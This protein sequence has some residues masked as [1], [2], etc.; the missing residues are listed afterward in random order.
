MI[1]LNIISKT[2][3]LGAAIFCRTI[4]KI[5]WRKVE[6]LPYNINKGVILLAPHTSNWDGFWGIFYA[7]AFLNYNRK[8]RA[9][10]K[11][12][13]V[14]VFTDDQL[15]QRM[16]VFNFNCAYCNGPFEHIDHV[17]PLSK[18]GLHCLS[19]LR[20]SCQS[21]NLSKHNKSLKN[22]LNSKESK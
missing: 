4:L 15:S 3:F 10:K 21:C 9:I 11:G 20:P 14:V 22:F 6:A 13:T 18:G 7:L 1:F 8:R 2:F 16:S 12:A 17:I 19:N 5:F